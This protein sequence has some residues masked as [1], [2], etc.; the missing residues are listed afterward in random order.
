MI[1]IKL[2]LS[3]LKNFETFEIVILLILYLTQYKLDV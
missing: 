3:I 2:E 1:V